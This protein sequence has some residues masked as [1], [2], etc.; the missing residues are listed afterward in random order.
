MLIMIVLATCILLVAHS[1]P[2]QESDP[3]PLCKCH[4]RGNLDRSPAA[5]PDGIHKPVE[6]LLAQG[7]QEGLRKRLDQLGLGLQDGL[8]YQTQKRV[9]EKVCEKVCGFFQVA[10]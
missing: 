8:G 2:Q 9:R 5:L 10:N 7:F 6:T 1:A 4:I 3:S